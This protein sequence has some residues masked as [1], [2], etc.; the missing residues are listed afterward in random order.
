MKNAANP[1]NK[2][3]SGAYLFRASD[4]KHR[5]PAIK[6]KL[7]RD[8]HC[9]KRYSNYSST[10]A[11]NTSG[12]EAAL[13]QLV[14]PAHIQYIVVYSSTQWPQV[15]LRP[16]DICWMSFPFSLSFLHLSC[17]IKGL[18]C[19]NKYLWSS[20]CLL[21]PVLMYLRSDGGWNANSTLTFDCRCSQKG[22]NF[23]I[24]VCSRVSLVI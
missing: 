3:S 6:Q 10:F 9:D 14:A 17:G 22:N 23:L 13:A 15:R 20:Q 18:K 1:N 2:P 8:T 4:N 11:L 12:P 16:A 5:P 21:W 24:N 7:F 19:P